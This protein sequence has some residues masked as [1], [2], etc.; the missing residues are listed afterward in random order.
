MGMSNET[1][2]N[3]LK[4]RTRHRKKDKK[5][6]FITQDEGCLFLN[7]GEP[8]EHMLTKEELDAIQNDE[9]NFIILVEYAEMEDFQHEI[10]KRS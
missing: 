4:K 10:Y 3:A 6:V 2:L 8:G 1:R 9:D 5:C 7:Y